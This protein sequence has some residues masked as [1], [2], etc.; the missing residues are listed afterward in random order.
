[1]NDHDEAIVMIGEIESAG[2]KL[3]DGLKPTVT[4][5]RYK[6]IAGQTA[7]QEN[8]GSQEPL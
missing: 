2:G 5:A 7:Q 4:K 6:F 8:N 3:Q 1:M